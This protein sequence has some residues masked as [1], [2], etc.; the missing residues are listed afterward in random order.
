MEQPCYQC[1]TPVEEG[2]AFCPQCNAP[3]I[4]VN[5]QMAEPP[6]PELPPT[7]LTPPALP[8]EMRWSRA[9]TPAIMAGVIAFLMVPFFF[10]AFGLG[11]ILAGIL[12]VVFYRW[13][14]PD[15]SVSPA[16]GMLLGA[17]SGFV[18]FLVLLFFAVSA[19]VM[20]GGSPLRQALEQAVARSPQASDPQSKQLLEM[21]QTQQGLLIIVIG[22]MIIAFFLIVV[23]TALGGALGASLLRRKPRE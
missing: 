22:C 11:M 3:L 17:L 20:G 1:N 5:V 7:A 4:R 16:S 12:S 21:I 19:T 2:T 18:G 8:T 10:G 23:L 13:R 15:A 6:I 14:S 9:I